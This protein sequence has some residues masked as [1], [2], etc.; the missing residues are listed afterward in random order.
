MFSHLPIKKRKIIMFTDDDSSGRHDDRIPITERN[1]VPSTSMEV[2]ETNQPNVSF[3]NDIIMINDGRNKRTRIDAITEANHFIELENAF[4][5]N[6]K[7]YYLKNDS[8]TVKDICM[9]LSLYKDE[10]ARIILNQVK[11]V[12]SIKF[13][14]LVECTYVKQQ[15]RERQD[16]AF[17]TKNVVL[18]AD[19]NLDSVLHTLFD[20]ICKEESVYEGR[21]SGWSLL[22]VDGIMIRINR[23]RPLGGSTFIPLPIEISKKKAVVNPTN[24]DDYCFKWAVLCHFVKDHR[25]RIDQRYHALCNR[26]NFNDIDFPTPLKQITKFERNNPNTS[27]NVYGLDEINNVYPLRITDSERTTHIDLLMIV[28]DAGLSHYCYISN[29]SRLISQQFSKHEHSIEVCKRCLTKFYGKTKIKKLEKHKMICYQNKAVRAIMPSEIVDDPIILKFKNTQYMFKLPIVIYADFESILKPVNVQTSKQTFVNNVHEPMSFCIYVVCDNSLPQFIRNIVPQ[30]PYLYRGLNAAKHFMTYIVE[31]AN[32]IGE[33][34]SMHNIEMLPLTIAEQ[35]RVKNA[36]QCEMCQKLFTSTVKPHRDHCHLTGRFRSVLCKH[37]NLRRQ[38]QKNLPIFIHGTA[39]YDSH[40]IVRQL[41]FDN[42]HI[43]VIPNSTEKYIT[44]SKQTSSG[45]TIRFID[46][47][48]IMNS[49][50]ATLVNNLPNDKFIHIKRFFSEEDLPLVT[51]KG[52][53]P[54]EYTSSWETLNETQLPTK[55]K[56]KNS[57]LNCD[58]SNEDYQHAT[59]VWNHFNISTLG[60]YSDLYLKL[61]V[62]LLSDVFENFRDLCLDSYELDCAHY[63]TLP[64]FT[65]DAML[66]HTK[67][68]LELLNDYNMYLFIEK[69]IRGGITSCVKRNATANNPYMG[70][71]YDPTLP[72]SYL[73]YLDCNNLY[74]WAMVQP[75][76]L[77]NFSWYIENLNEFDVTIIPN[78]SDIGYFLEVDVEYPTSLHNEHNDLPFLPSSECPPNSKFKKLLTTLKSKEN[79]VCHYINL[80]QALENGLVLKKIHRI[81]QFN[82]SC[83]LKS[84][85]DLNTQKRQKAKNDFEKDFYKLLNNSMF[86]K[87]IENIRKRINLELVSNQKRLDKLINKPTFLDRIIYDE[88]LCAVQ[89]AKENII[90]DKPIYIGF[91][92]LEISKFKMYDFHYRIMK[93]RYGPNIDVLY[94]DTDAFFYKIRTGDFY[95]DLAHDSEFNKHF[96]LSDY[97][98]NHECYSS[99]NKKVLGKFKDECNST[100]M[101][102]FIGLRPKLYSFKTLTPLNKVIV[103]DNPEPNVMKK[104]KGV[105]KGIVH[106]EILFNDYKTCLLTCEKMRKKTMLFRSRKHKIETITCNKIALSCDDD[107]RHILPNGIDTLAY[108]HYD[109]NSSDESDESDF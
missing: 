73:M 59:R 79:Y 26:F 48:K 70:P 45:V 53:Y 63:L 3:D 81:L 52:V 22:C 4:K 67:V 6:L 21:G 40:F 29:L 74:G 27:I 19:N 103:D 57:I 104:A 76:P 46:T 100:I 30:S 25:S 92:V 15:T 49:S 90:F 43:N 69:G 55:D 5:G 54:Y 88:S 58:I 102:E 85:I 9:L 101:L 35:D 106:K 10:M 33:C 47:Y 99:K 37:C 32:N 98:V 64:S 13:N 38:N 28:N 62:L 78:D 87:T 95:N 18:Y 8:R 56:F 108:G 94:M 34:I 44:F 31:L 86:G 75:M 91:S 17:K 77:K 97:P 12:G 39:N 107:K 41:G 68:E 61:D 80:K 96:D 11:L 65:F 72:N 36:S 83:W 84:Y 23:F 20:K 60:E 82:Q 2:D 109:L 105:T 14:L 1:V 42:R 51:R 16:R 89:C 7:T 50:L 66:K 24:I 71:D 93:P